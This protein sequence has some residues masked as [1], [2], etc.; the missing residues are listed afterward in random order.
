MVALNPGFT[1]YRTIDQNGL[2]TLSLIVCI[3]VTLI[4]FLISK[5]K[6]KK[7]TD[8]TTKGIGGWKGV[9]ISLIVYGLPVP[10]LNEMFPR[11]IKKTFKS[12]LISKS[13]HSARK[14]RPSFLMLRFK[15]IEDTQG[16]VLRRG[17]SIGIKLNEGSGFVSGDILELTFQKGLFGYYI[18]K[19]IKRI[20]KPT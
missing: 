2:L 7:L 14:D 15:P 1:M 16:V 9:V 10:F 12:E 6:N 11:G 18:V 13:N 17:E 4:E 20:D 5:S 3:V 8:S 19:N